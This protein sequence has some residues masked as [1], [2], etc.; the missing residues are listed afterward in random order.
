[1]VF[2][3]RFV[4]EQHE[5][6]T[7]QI[8]RQDFGLPSLLTCCAFLILAL[9]EGLL[10]PS[11][12]PIIYR[13]E[14]ASKLLRVCRTDNHKMPTA[15]SYPMRKLLLII[16]LVGEQNQGLDSPSYPP[17]WCRTKCINGTKTDAHTS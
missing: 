9:S 3:L 16:G 15:A 4:R 5:F 7:R 8:L 1:M 2:L 12:S 13:R 6:E 14:T 11:T 10:F 17:C